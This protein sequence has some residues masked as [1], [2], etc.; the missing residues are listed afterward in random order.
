MSDTNLTHIKILS[1]NY[2]PRISKISKI[3]IHHMAAM[4][5][6]EQCG[7]SFA[8]PARQAS[9][10]YGVDSFG[11]IGLYVPE[12][13]RAWTS[14]TYGM[15]PDN[16]DMAV[17]I[18]VANDSGAPDWTVS[19]KAIDMVIKLCADICKRNNIKSLNY[20]GDTNGNLTRHNMFQSTECPGKYLQSYFPYIAESVNN[21]LS[22]SEEKPMTK[23][24]RKEFDDLKNKVDELFDNAG[25][26]WAYNDK[27]IPEFASPTITKLINKGY[28]KGNNKN[29]LELSYDF[30]RTLT[31]LDRA[32][33]FD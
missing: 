1:P 22:E 25:V 3:T 33:L 8:N 18:E 32:K 29:S 23:E 4:W 20:T 12:N 17:T 15:T 6:V 9:S 19:S 16:D 28:L 24:E 30:I 21:I 5:T 27:N 2:S 14:G 31:L 11:Q 7:N 26:R 10:N 13:L